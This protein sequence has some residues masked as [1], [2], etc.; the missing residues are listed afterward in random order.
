[1]K[2][3][4]TVLF[5]VV[6]LLYLGPIWAFVGFIIGFVFDRIFDN[7]DSFIV[8]WDSIKAYWKKYPAT[9]VISLAYFIII[10]TMLIGFVLSKVRK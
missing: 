5:P 1:M 2:W 9:Q 8:T 6:G 10:L 3:V 4:L 7:Y